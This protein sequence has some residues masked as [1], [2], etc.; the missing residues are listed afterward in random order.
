MHYITNIKSL[1]YKGIYLS[2]KNLGW[3]PLSASKSNCH[4]RSEKS[5]QVGVWGGRGEIWDYG[6]S[7]YKDTLDNLIDSSDIESPNWLYSLDRPGLINK[8]S[9]N[10][11]RSKSDLLT[12]LEEN[13]LHE[14]VL[15]TLLEPVP[16]I[17]APQVH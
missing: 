2:E 8:G 16:K 7:Q 13:C 5:I 14:G 3:N 10:A 9:R 6:N 4:N 12:L 11:P 1:F 15:V 17:Q